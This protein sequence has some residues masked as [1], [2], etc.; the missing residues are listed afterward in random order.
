MLSIL[1]TIILSQ[2][3]IPDSKYG[4]G[5]F[6][7]LSDILSGNNIIFLVSSAISLFFIFY[8]SQ[9]NHYN[10]LLSILLIF[11]FSGSILFQKYFEPMFLIMF[12]LIFRSNLILVFEN[13]LKNASILFFYYILYTFVAVTDL[14]YKI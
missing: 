12:F 14:I 9:E 7:K 10:F 13:N 1:I 4:Y 3:F 5:I 6:Y 8:I 11:G 2:Q